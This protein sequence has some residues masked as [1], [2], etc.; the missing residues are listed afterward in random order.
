MLQRLS[1]LLLYFCMTLFFNN[2]YF[3]FVNLYIMLAVIFEVMRSHF[4]FLGEAI[5]DYWSLSY[6]CVSLPSL[7]F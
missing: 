3:I 5:L 6:F 1:L 2:V 7:T 4:G